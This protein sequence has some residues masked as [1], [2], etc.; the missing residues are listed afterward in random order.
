MA[1]EH[2]LVVRNLMYKSVYNHR[3]NEICSWLL[4]LIARTA[5]DLGPQ[6]V[7]TD[8]IMKKW[9]WGK[10]VIS[11][12]TY[13]AN[14]DIQ[15]NDFSIRK[16]QDPYLWN[17]RQAKGTKIGI[18][19]YSSILNS[20]DTEYADSLLELLRQEGINPRAIWVS[21]LKTQSVQRKV[22]KLFIGYYLVYL[23]A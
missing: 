14:D 8:E 10:G 6:E 18:I 5:R 13:L 19:F 20:G 3:L 2:Y 1:V 9:L 15:I 12:K 17:W 7:W 23:Q 16:I 4:E 22:I 21:S 11:L